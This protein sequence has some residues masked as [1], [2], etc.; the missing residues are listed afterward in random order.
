ML[1]RFGG[2]L[3]VTPLA[4]AAT[5]SPVAWAAAQGRGLSGDK[6]R[7]GHIVVVDNKAWRVQQA[8]KSQKGQTGVTFK[9][10]MKL[11]GGDKVKDVTAQQQTD[12]PEPPYE[13]L[14]LLFSGFDDDDNACFVY[15]QH[16]AKAGQE[17]NIPASSLPQLHQDWLA[18]G[19]PVDIMHIFGG[20]G[21]DADV[22]LAG[23]KEFWGEAQLPGNYTYSVDKITMKAMTRHASFEECDGSIAVTDVVQPSDKVKVNLRTSD[24]GAT[25]GGKVE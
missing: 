7:A 23:L 5:A 16:S 25:F 14:K 4:T 1:R 9:L 10:K 15:P 20:D 6:V 18:C 19:M 2:R 24:G 21:E 13:R 11:V 8:A 22:K 17:V 3:P 12:L